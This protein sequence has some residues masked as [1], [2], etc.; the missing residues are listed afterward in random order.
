MEACASPQAGLLVESE[1][2][3]GKY[4]LSISDRADR[5]HDAIELNSGYRPEGAVRAVYLNTSVHK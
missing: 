3:G 2:L 5:P 4:V 1:D